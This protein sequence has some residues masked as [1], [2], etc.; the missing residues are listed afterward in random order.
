MLNALRRIS[1]KYPL[2]LAVLFCVSVAFAQNTNSATKESAAGPAKDPVASSLRMLL[3]RS[4]HNIEGA[5][6]AMP[7]DKF[8]YKPT[9][10][11]MTFAHLVVHIIES[12]NGL[13]AKAADVPAPK[14]QEPK[15]SESKD[16]L[17]SALRASFAFCNEAL[18]KMNDSKLGDEV[19]LFG[20]RQFPRA[21]AALAVAS[22]WADHY[23]AAAMYLRLNGILPPTAQHQH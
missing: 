21:M 20:G 6:E 13:C 18:G 15:E 22:G 23:G 9:P 1:V 12:N 7:A 5:V 4:E 2:A 16:Q 10:E 3:P 19:E 14:V 11:Q 8:S 17:L